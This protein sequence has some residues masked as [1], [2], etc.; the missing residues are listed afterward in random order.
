MRIFNKLFNKILHQSLSIKLLA[1]SLLLWGWS[2]PSISINV[3]KKTKTVDI[4]GF[5]EVMNSLLGQPDDSFD[6]F[7]KRFSKDSLFQK[8]RIS[9][10]VKVTSIDDEGNSVKWIKNKEWEYTDF[11]NVKNARIKQE[12]ISGESE[13]LIFMI[14]DTGVLIYHYFHKKDGKW[15]LV[16]I[17]DLSN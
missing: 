16:S 3:Y 14:E 7:F 10:P 12:K 11:F 9:F 2:R 17:E 13:K 4:A 15:M 5:P 1:L 8:E 6:S